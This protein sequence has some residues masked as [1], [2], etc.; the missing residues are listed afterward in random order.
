VTLL[1]NTGTASI[2]KA[3]RNLKAL[4]AMSRIEEMFIWQKRRLEGK[5]FQPNIDLTRDF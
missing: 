4:M 2:L 1:V 5:A 3:N